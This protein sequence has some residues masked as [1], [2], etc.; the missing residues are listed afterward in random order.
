MIGRYS[1]GV[2]KRQRHQVRVPKNVFF[3]ERQIEPLATIMPYFTS[4]GNHERDAPGT[5][6]FQHGD[7]SG[8]ECGVPFNA[9][10]IQPAA[11]AATPAPGSGSTDP[12]APFY[13]WWVSFAWCC[14]QIQQPQIMHAGVRFS[15]YLM[16]VVVVW[17]CCWWCCWR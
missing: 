10:F 11:D 15:Q 17:C 16:L 14:E 3:G 4:P 13:S 9:R 8:G 1:G 5:G 6:A 2:S 12:R 7:D